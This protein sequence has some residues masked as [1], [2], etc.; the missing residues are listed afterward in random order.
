MLCVLGHYDDGRKLAEASKNQPFRYEDLDELDFPIYFWGEVAGYASNAFMN[1]QDNLAYQAYTL[2]KSITSSF[3]AKRPSTPLD[4]TDC[5]AVIKD[6]CRRLQNPEPPV[7]LVQLKGLPQQER[8]HKL[9]Q[10]LDSISTVVA[11]DFNSNRIYPR[12]TDFDVVQGLI[13]EGS[14]A[15]PALFDCIEHD[16]R[17]TRSSRFANY[18]T[19]KEPAFITVCAILGVSR[20][21]DIDVF[22]YYPNPFWRP[23]QYLPIL[24]RMWSDLGPLAPEERYYRILADDKGSPDS[25]FEAAVRLMCPQDIYRTSLQGFEKSSF[26]EIVTPS[27]GN[28]VQPEFDEPLAPSTEKLRSKAS[29]SLSQLLEKR[30]NQLA[31]LNEKEQWNRIDRLKQAVMIARY[32]TDWDPE[33]GL[34]LLK[35]LDLRIKPFLKI[36]GSASS[37]EGQEFTWGNQLRAK[38]GDS[39][40][41]PEYIDLLRAFHLEQVGWGYEWQF[42]LAPVVSMR[43]SSSRSDMLEELFNGKDSAWNPSNQEVDAAN[44]HILTALFELPAFRKSIFRMLDNKQPFGETSYEGQYVVTKYPNGSSGAYLADA[45]APSEGETRTIRACDHTALEIAYGRIGAPA[46]KEYWPEAKKDEAIK[47]IKAYLRDHTQEII[48]QLKR[49]G[50]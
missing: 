50:R 22:N 8:I 28:Q 15:V 1:G 44:S 33:A 36:P 18:S 46:F 16:D 11:E 31:G 27:T 47:Q 45:F 38:L 13:K 26:F 24:K 7:D 23:E 32:L 35:S 2:D 43:D 48:Q 5:D 4:Q 19:V 42:W 9:I 14:A 49:M 6:I 21:G 3:Y 20:V 29:P 25:W 10:G 34:P 41:M 39:S 12:F 30:A 37:L 40:A 17:L